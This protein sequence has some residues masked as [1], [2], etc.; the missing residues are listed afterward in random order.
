M[1]VKYIELGKLLSE[2]SKLF[3]AHLGKG[4]YGS[5]RINFANG[6]ARNANIEQSV[7]ISQDRDK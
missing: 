6:E 5:I 7:K 3:S 2:V 1:S 4:F